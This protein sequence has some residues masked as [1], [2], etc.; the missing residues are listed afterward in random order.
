MPEMTT[1]YQHTQLDGTELRWAVDGR[2]AGQVMAWAARSPQ[3]LAADLRGMADYFPHWLLVGTMEALPRLCPQCRQLSVPVEGAVRCLRCRR[4]QAVDGLAWLGH[5]PLLTRPEAAFEVKRQ[6]LRQAGFQEVTTGQA[7]YLLVPLVILYPTEWPNVEPT[8]RYDRR[9]L[10]AMG[11][12]HNSAAHHL[13][14]NGRA[15]IFSW[16]QWQAMPIHAVLQQRM[17][18][19]LHSLC[20]IAAGQRPEQAFI[21]RVHDQPWQ[22][23]H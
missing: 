6:A 4:K 5:L 7:A 8:V 10:T 19:H 22:P 3:V 12:P 2:A 9:W 21:G 15:C 13:I 16:N 1:T 14:Q 20:K 11:L 23:E 18:N 17:V